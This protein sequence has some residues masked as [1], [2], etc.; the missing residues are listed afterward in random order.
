MCMGSNEN[1]T[2]L[3]KRLCNKQLVALLASVT[4]R[5]RICVCVCTVLY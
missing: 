1:K 4:G 5:N 2:M 3:Q